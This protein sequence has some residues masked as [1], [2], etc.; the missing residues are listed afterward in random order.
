MKTKKG[1]INEIIKTGINKYVTNG[2]K[3]ILKKG[4]NKLIL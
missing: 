3:N 4:V 1:K 2:T